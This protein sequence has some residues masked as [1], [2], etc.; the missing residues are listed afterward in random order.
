MTFGQMGEQGADKD[1]IMHAQLETPSGLTL[2]GSDTPASMGEPRPNGSVSLSGDNASEAE[3][4]GY[5]DKLS[6]GGQ[7]MMP[8]AKAQWGDSFGMLT[9]KF[10]VSWMVNIAGQPQQ[11]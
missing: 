8:L 10:G 6:A 3:L 9:D 4:K 1:K 2:M 11:Q 5:W 7:V